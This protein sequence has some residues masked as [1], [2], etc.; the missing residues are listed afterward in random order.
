MRPKRLIGRGWPERAG[1]LEHDLALKEAS[2]VPACWPRSERI[3]CR[4]SHA[5]QQSLTLTLTLALT[6]TC[7]RHR[8]DQGHCLRRAARLHTVA[9]SITYGYRRDQG[10]RVRRAACALGAALGGGARHRPG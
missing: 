3:C 7:G 4:H 5:V 9:A 10:H 8:R 1:G 6:L 2:G